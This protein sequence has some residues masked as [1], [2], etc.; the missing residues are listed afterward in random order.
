MDKE[1]WIKH[2]EEI[3][4]ETRPSKGGDIKKWYTA[5]RLHTSTDPDCPTC[6]ERSKTRKS[7]RNRHS[8]LKA[9]YNNMRSRE[10]LYKS[11]G[12]KKVKGSAGGT[13]WEDI[14]KY[15]TKEEIIFLKEDNE[16]SEILEEKKIPPM[17]K[18]LIKKK[19]FKGKKSEYK[20]HLDKLARGDEKEF[21]E[22]ETGLPEDIEKYAT[23]EEME[24]LLEYH[25]KTWFNRKQKNLLNKWIDK[26]WKEIHKKMPFFDIDEYRDMVKNKGDK[27]K[28]F[29]EMYKKL[30]EIDIDPLDDPQILANDVREYVSSKVFGKF[31]NQNMP[32]WYKSKSAEFEED[33]EKYATPEE[34]EFLL[35]GVGD[36]LIELKY[37]LTWVLNNT[38]NKQK[39]LDIFTQTYKELGREKGI[40]T[41]DLVDKVNRLKPTLV[42]RKIT[43]T[44]PQ[45]ASGVANKL[46]ALRKTEHPQV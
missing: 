14:M 30:N 5:R 13:Y 4:G 23:P 11:V 12:L 19:K 43:E 35:E 15:G 36:D 31:L 2:I 10:E 22:E 34:M 40:N 46:R 25:T 37:A 6:L 7:L 20:E 28:E 29:D 8:S 9:Y 32:E 21:L 44:D 33:I 3:S 45:L 39:V 18:R 1:G 24:F 42:A 38:P 17:I 27:L 41:Q 16:E 26:N